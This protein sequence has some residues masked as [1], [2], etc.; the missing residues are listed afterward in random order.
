M[1]ETFADNPAGRWRFFSD[2]VMGGVSSGALH[3]DH[4]DIRNWAWMTG[5]V[6]TENNGGFIQM[7]RL[8]EAPLPPG[9]TGVLLTA[10]GNDQ[11]YFIHLRRTGASAPTAFYRAGFD[12]TSEWCKTRLPFA[13]FI[14]SNG[15]IPAL[16]EGSDLASVGIVGYGRNHHAD[17]CVSEIGFY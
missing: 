11:R 10:R 3:F 14:A 16:L 13:L 1:I 4:D 15:G 9:L 5:M 12:V 6:S 7:Q 2:Q 17:I 8:V